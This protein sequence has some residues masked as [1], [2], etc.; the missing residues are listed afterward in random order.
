MI[1][2]M[3][4][5]AGPRQCGKTSLARKFLEEKRYFL[6]W[7]FVGSESGRFENMIASALYRFVTSHNDRGWPEVRLWMENFHTACGI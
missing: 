4:F 7:I 2:T 3:L 6:D 1:N 5:I